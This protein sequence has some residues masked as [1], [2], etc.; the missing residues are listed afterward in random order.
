MVRKAT[1]CAGPAR[2]NGVTDKRQRI[3]LRFAETSGLK[4]KY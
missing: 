2:G 3:D 4:R 1:A